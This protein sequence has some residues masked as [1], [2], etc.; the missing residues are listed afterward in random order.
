MKHTRATLA[1]RKADP[2]RQIFPVVWSE[3]RRDVLRRTKA[4]ELRGESLIDGPLSGFL[5]QCADGEFRDAETGII[6][7]LEENIDQAYGETFISL[8]VALFVLQRMDLVATMLRDMFGFECP[9]TLKFIDSKIG[10]GRVQWDISETREHTF[11]FDAEGLRRD[12]TRNECLNFYWIFRLLAHYAKQREQEPGS[13]FLYY[14]D[15]SPAPGLAYCGSKPEDFLVPDGIFVSSL[16]YE[17]F[18][19]TVARKH[20]PWQDRKAVAFWRGATTG[21]RP[22]A[23]DWRALGR[24]KLCEIA[25]ANDRGGLFDVGISGV[26]QFSDADIIQEILDTG[27]VRGPVPAVDW[28]QYKYLIDIDGNAS[29]FAGLYQRLLTGSPV[30]KVDSNKALMQWFYWELIPWHNYV[31]V[32]PDMW[33]LADKVRWLNK[34]DSIA[35]KIGMNGRALAEAM[36][37]ERELSRSVPVISSAFRYFRDPKA[38]IL[39]HGMPLRPT[40]GVPTAAVVDD[41]AIKSLRFL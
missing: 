5:L 32:A 6:T 28:G 8:L 14:N 11:L 9:I 2:G 26:A 18:K 33:D 36:T 24:I 40:I 10:V 34:N 29:A 27:F 25:Q 3:A 37:F 38:Y 13:T 23:R 16:G 19:T 15:I 12:T 17:A 22:G 1:V 41:A 21:L 30:L 20:V 4:G 7:I 35:E 31:P 39:P